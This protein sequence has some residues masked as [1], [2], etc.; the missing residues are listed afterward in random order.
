MERQGLAIRQHS[1]ARQKRFAICAAFLCHRVHPQRGVWASTRTVNCC[2]PVGFAA[3]RALSG[4]FDQ[5]KPPQSLAAQTFAFD[6][7]TLRN[8]IRKNVRS[9]SQMTRGLRFLS[10]FL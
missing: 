7:K 3:D 9:A 10:A 6:C 1:A 8:R 2:G 4:Q 5:D